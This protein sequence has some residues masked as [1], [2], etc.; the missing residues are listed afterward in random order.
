MPSAYDHIPKPKATPKER[1][2]SA[3]GRPQTVAWAVGVL[4]VLLVL[5][6][7]STSLY[8]ALR[9]ILLVLVGSGVTW[10]AGKAR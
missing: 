4:G 6:V 8:D 9:G 3:A 7:A 10:L 2:R 5:L 1:L